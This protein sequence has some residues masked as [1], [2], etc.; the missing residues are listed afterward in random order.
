MLRGSNAL[1][2]LS[3]N[4]TLASALYCQLPPDARDKPRSTSANDPKRTFDKYSRAALKATIKRKEA[5]PVGRPPGF[6]IPYSRFLEEM[7]VLRMQVLDLQ[8]RECDRVGRIKREDDAVAD[9][10]QVGLHRSEIGKLAIR[11][12]DDVVLDGEIAR[13]VRRRRAMSASGV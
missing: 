1:A 6:Q 10:M 3:K 5:A 9:G 11:Q 13:D 7:E 2:G 4:W 12:I 8:V